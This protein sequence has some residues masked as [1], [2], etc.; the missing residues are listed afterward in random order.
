MLSELYLNADSSVII[1]K[2][3]AMKLIA[4]QKI[5]SGTQ[6]KSHPPKGMKFFNRDGEN[7]GWRCNNCGTRRS[8]RD[9]SF[10]E[11]SRLSLVK[12]QQ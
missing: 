3:M 10:F 2:L 9:G 1:E 6:K 8:M 4:S 7:S 11:Q 5:C 12:L